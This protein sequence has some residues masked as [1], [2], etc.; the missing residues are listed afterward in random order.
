[1][2]TPNTALA[3]MGPAYERLGFSGQDVILMSS[4][5]GHQTGYLYGFATAVLLG[6]TGVWLDVWNADTGARLIEAERVTFTMGATP[7]ER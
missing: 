5:F 3:L 4:T 7:A 1:M 2:H 6:A